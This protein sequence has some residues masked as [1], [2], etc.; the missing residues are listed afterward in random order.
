M[1]DPDPHARGARRPS[2][3][4]VV[5]EWGRI[6]CIGFDRVKGVLAIRRGCAMPTVRC[7]VSPS[8][9]S[10][11]AAH[12]GLPRD[13]RRCESEGGA[14]DVGHASAAMTLD[15]YAD[16]C[17]S[18]L[19]SVAESVGKMCPR[20]SQPHDCSTPEA[21]LPAPTGTESGSPLSGLN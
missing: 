6:G 11:T 17:D 19:S 15:V 8:H 10:R 5:R 21:P 20:E 13:Q 2:L 14:T 7:H 18:D 12:G 9:G 4:V 1:C 16:L 3:T